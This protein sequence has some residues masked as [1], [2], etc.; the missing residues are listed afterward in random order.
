[1][2]EARRWAAGG[3]GQSVRSAGGRPFRGT[4]LRATKSGILSKPR[5]SWLVSSSYLTP[6]GGLTLF[7][8]GDEHTVGRGAV[9]DADIDL[10]SG[11][12]ARARA[13]DSWGS[14]GERTPRLVLCKKVRSPWWFK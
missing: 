11:G 3:H 14:I 13:H 12:R 6:A 8:E 10:L 4:A 7:H 9:A 5:N 1:M 2:Q